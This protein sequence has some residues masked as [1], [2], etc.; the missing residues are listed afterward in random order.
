MTIFPQFPLDAPRW[1]EKL[2]SYLRRHEGLRLKP[3]TDTTGH[4]TIGYGRNLT[5][6]IDEEEAEFLLCRDST[7]AV[8]QA[9]LIFGALFEQLSDVRKVVVA[10]MCFN[11]GGGG[12]R[13]F[14]KFVA[15]VAEGNF[16]AAATE[17]LNSRW[18]EQVGTRAHR[19]ASMMRTGEWV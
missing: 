8:Q 4:A 2:K 6:G 17:M 7:R 3:Y 5:D 11:L 14:R 10:D 18:A 16:E 19:L 15:A 9:R 13:Q 12:V 1:I